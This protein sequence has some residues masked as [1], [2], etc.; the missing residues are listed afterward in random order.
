MFY[1]PQLDQFSTTNNYIQYVKARR[2]WLDLMFSPKEKH[3][4]TNLEDILENAMKCHMLI[5]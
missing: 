1:L 4:M 2:I 5:T 3:E